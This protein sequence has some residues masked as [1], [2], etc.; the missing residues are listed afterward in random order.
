MKILHVSK[1]VK[2]T[3]IKDNDPSALQKSILFFLLFLFCMSKKKEQA[4][5]CSANIYCFQTVRL[6][7]PHVHK[8]FRG[9]RHR[10][11]D[12]VAPGFMGI[13]I[14]AKMIAFKRG[15]MSFK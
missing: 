3:S 15:F 8:L 12:N 10:P 9:S 5:M 7:S 13:Q 4:Y 11:G 1:V 6:L 2:Q 14:M